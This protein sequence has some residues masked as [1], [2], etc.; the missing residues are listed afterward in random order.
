MKSYSSFPMNQKIK[1]LDT[2]NDRF[3]TSEDGVSLILPFTTKTGRSVA[4]NRQHI[5]KF[6]LDKW[7]QDTF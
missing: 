1:T 2:F 4:Q 5:F 7:K 3:M 6:L